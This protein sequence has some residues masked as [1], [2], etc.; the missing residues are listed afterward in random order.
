LLWRPTGSVYACMSEGASS[1][2]P[3]FSSIE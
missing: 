3:T 2:Y 1:T